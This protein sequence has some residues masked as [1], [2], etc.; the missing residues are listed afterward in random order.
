VGTEFVRGIKTNHWTSCVFAPELDN[1]TA[2]VD[3]YFAVEDWVSSM[4][5]L[6]APVPVRAHWR[7]TRVNAQDPYTAFPFES[8]YEYSNFLPG[9]EVDPSVF[10]TP[11]G[12]Y[13][14]GRKA[15]RA[16]PTVPTQFKM[17]VE[18]IQPRSIPM[19][20]NIIHSARFWFD[21]HLNL[22]RVDYKPVSQIV[23]DIGSKHEMSEI[24][25]YKNRLIYVQASATVK[26]TMLR[27][28]I[29]N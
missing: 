20:V 13:C 24:Y 17:G 23:T 7:G 29:T 4:G 8:V 15:E 25:D 27:N 3:W 2:I 21:N 12:V 26:Q 14:E 6:F 18:V 10:N 5:P 19:P 22:S 9:L 1:V 28:N 16:K 11:P